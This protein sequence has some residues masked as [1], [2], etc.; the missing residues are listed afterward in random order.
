V[1][2]YTDRIDFLTL[3]G[4]AMRWIGVVLGAIGGTLRILPVFVLERGRL[5]KKLGGER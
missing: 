3:D 4:E 2:A 5:V 1:P